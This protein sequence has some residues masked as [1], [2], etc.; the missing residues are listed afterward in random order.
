[1][2]DYPAPPAH[3]EP[4]VRVLGTPAAIDFLLTFGGGEMYFTHNPQGRSRLEE[5]VGSQKA[6]ALAAAIPQLKARVPTAKPW[7]AQCLRTEGASVA[8][9][10]RRLHSTDVS[11][12]RW[13]QA[14]FRQKPED[15]RQMRL[16]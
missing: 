11:V 8:E 4:Y 16:F 1:M 14:E 15:P 10:A 9:I 6:V 5:V 7:I 12:R 13:L 3:V 2:T